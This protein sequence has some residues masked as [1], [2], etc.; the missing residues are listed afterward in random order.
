MEEKNYQNKQKLHKNMKTI[1]CWPS[2]PE[3]EACPIE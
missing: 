2:T 1:S 3:Y